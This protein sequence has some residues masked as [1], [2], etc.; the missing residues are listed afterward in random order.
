VIQRNADPV[1]QQNAADEVVAIQNATQAK[2]EGLDPTTAYNFGLGTARAQKGAGD[3]AKAALPAFG[4][5]GAVAL[6][7]VL[8]VVVVKV[9]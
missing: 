8:L 2:Q 7:L 4:V 6:A 3:L 1:Y 9:A 5:L